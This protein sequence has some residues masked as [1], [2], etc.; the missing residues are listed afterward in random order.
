[1]SAND[2]AQVFA[3]LLG[4]AYSEPSGNVRD[5]L[6][7]Q[8]KEV[9]KRFKAALKRSLPHLSAEELVW[10]MHFVF[11]A[12]SY[13]QSGADALRLVAK[14]E[15]SDGSYPVTVVQRLLPFVCAGLQ[16][17]ASMHSSVALAMVS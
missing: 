11:G 10:R 17:P 16:A 9:I 3:Q 15:L 5:I 12:I 2:G 14:Y 13:T 6:Y 7:S 8:N 1:E 4:R